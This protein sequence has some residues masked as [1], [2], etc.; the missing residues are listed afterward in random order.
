MVIKRLAG[1][2]QG[3]SALGTV[4]KAKA[5]LLFQFRDVLR[6]TRLRRMH[7]LGGLAEVLVARNCHETWEQTDIEH[8]QLSPG[9]VTDY[10]SLSKATIN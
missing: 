2:R 9:T 6:N 4:E 5:K 3:D 8:R 1:G 7:C 10:A